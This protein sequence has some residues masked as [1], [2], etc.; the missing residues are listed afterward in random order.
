M[1][2]NL[3][4]ECKFNT[5]QDKEILPYLLATVPAEAAMP[6]SSEAG[7]GVKQVVGVDPDGAGLNED[8]HLQRQV[9][10]LRPHTGPQSVV[11][12]VTQR[13]RLLG[14]AEWQ[15]YEHRA[16]DL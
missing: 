3:I 12:I 11:G 16:K 15:G 2:N 4:V 8:G 13:H 1:R 7:G 10:V 5:V 9:H 6:V 14:S